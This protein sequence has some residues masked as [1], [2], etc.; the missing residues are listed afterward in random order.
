MNNF[1]Q[2]NN[3]LYYNQF[4]IKFLSSRKNSNS[5]S[6]PNIILSDYNSIHWLDK[7]NKN[8]KDKFIQR[9]KDNIN[10]IKNSKNDKINSLSKKTSLN[11]LKKSKL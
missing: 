11:N 5:N 2:R 9:V 7:F 10:K 3:N 6:N 8:K 1:T 4:L